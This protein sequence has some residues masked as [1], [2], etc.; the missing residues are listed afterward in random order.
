MATMRS[1]LSGTAVLLTVFMAAGC[2]RRTHP[3]GEL[4]PREPLPPGGP[5]AGQIPPEVEAARQRAAE[6]DPPRPRGH[7]SAVSAITAARCDREQRCDHIGSGKRYASRDACIK[8]V[9]G[10]WQR[11]LTTIECPKGIVQAKLDECVDQIRTEGCANPIE[12]LG[13]MTSCRQIEICRTELS[14]VR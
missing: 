13:R 8:Q 3:D 1:C 7:G 12:T 2:E 4:A 11:E 10:D 6:S 5:M 14:Q 9:Q